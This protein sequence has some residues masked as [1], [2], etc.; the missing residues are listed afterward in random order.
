[1]L[2]G[3]GVAPRDVFAL[4]TGATR[5][6]QAILDL[7]LPRRAPITLDYINFLSQ[8]GDVEAAERVWDRLLHMNLPF[9]LHQTSPYLDALIQNRQLDQLAEAWS[10]LDRRF[11]GKLGRRVPDTNL[12]TNGSFESEILNMGFDWRVVPVEGA[13]VSV[14]SL[15]S[16]DGDRSLRIEFD[17]TRNLEYWHVFQFVPVRPKTRYR[18]SGYMRQEGITTD[19]GPRFELYDAYEMSQFFVST[20]NTIGTSDWSTQQVEFETKAN[21]HLLI[22]RVARPP[23]RKFDNQIAGT[24]WIDQVTVEPEN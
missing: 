12:V 3:S 2:L 16:R 13:I 11:P 19:S 4:A 9:D 21:T 8:T 22:L 6:D 17:G 5:D 18:F 14:D 10:I 24:V 15:Q 20:G 7:A 23:S 1:V